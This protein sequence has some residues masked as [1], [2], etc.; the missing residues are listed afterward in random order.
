MSRARGT[1]IFAALSLLATAVVLLAITLPVVALKV[2]GQSAPSLVKAVQR[3]T[4]GQTALI[5]LIP[6]ISDG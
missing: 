4:A 1:G 2:S 3:I 6:Q 5:A